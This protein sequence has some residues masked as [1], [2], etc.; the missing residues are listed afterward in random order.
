MELVS[1]GGVS[2]GNVAALT[3]IASQLV[4]RVRACYPEVNEWIVQC[5]Y[6]PQQVHT[7]R[8]LTVRRIGHVEQFI[9]CL[10]Q[11]Q[12][13]LSSATILNAFTG[14]MF[15]VAFLI[16]SNMLILD[17]NS[18]KLSWFFAKE[19]V[20]GE[21]LNSFIP[22]EEDRER[23]RKCMESHDNIP[24]CVQLQLADLTS[25]SL[26]ATLTA[27]A[28]EYLIGVEIR[29]HTQVA[30][31]VVKSV[32]FSDAVYEQICDS[33]EAASSSIPST[34]VIR[35]W[36]DCGHKKSRFRKTMRQFLNRDFAESMSGLLSS[37]DYFTSD[38]KWMIPRYVVSSPLL[39]FEEVVS[40]LP[41]HAQGDFLKAMN[42][43]DYFTCSQLLENCMEGNA[44]ILST[45]RTRLS[46]N[47]D[48]LHC[49]FRL[50]VS[51]VP[52]MPSSSAYT[53]L[54]LLDNARKSVCASLG[55]LGLFLTGM[56]VSLALLSIAEAIPG[57]VSFYWLD[58]AFTD[59]FLSCD[60]MSANQNSFLVDT[61]F[62]LKLLWACATY[63]MGHEIE[64]VDSLKQL[65]VDTQTSC[66]KYPQATSIRQI[67]S[68][69]CYNLAIY[70]MDSFSECLHW[71]CELETVANCTYVT[72]PYACIQLIHWARDVQYKNN[73]HSVYK[74]A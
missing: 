6:S 14:V 70:A 67:Q 5:A 9:V 31:P 10:I 49:V 23:F 29:E 11:P 54:I 15:D 42:E 44:N 63:R 72:L 60:E 3:P 56:E 52:H 25:C 36:V 30:P 55:R 13:P 39:T 32:R 66:V 65:F 41:L 27:E 53:L 47:V 18:N 37:S 50:F 22:T 58:R 73:D 59:V 57:L 21:S 35:D 19:N 4:D 40:A 71:A 62:W 24:C 20:S 16:D 68:I 43:N 26:F 33:S 51:R 7:N 69:V 45:S 38:P 64:A 61:I 2:N 34:D 1:L 28:N 46:S 17:D 48:L 74:G 12:P 8:Y